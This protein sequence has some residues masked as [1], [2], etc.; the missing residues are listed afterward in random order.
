[1]H[2]RFRMMNGLFSMID[3]KSAARA[4]G[5]AHAHARGDARARVR[6]LTPTAGFGRRYAAEIGFPS[7][8]V[9]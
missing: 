1:M 4:H 5:D 7:F 6:G 8:S 2:T 9:G 3:E